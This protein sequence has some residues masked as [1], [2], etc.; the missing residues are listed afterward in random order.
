MNSDFFPSVELIK[1]TAAAGAAMA[2]PIFDQT[3]IFSSI[4]DVGLQLSTVDS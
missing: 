2:A 1:L 4:S 3:K